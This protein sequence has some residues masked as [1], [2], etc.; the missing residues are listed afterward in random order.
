MVERIPEEVLKTAHLRWCRRVAAAV[1]MAMAETGATYQQLEAR[2]GTKPGT[3]KRWLNK[4]I[5]GTTTEGRE[6]TDICCALNAE[7]TLTIRHWADVVHEYEPEI[8]SKEEMDEIE[9]AAL[10]GAVS[11]Q[12]EP[13]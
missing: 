8:I 11:S 3:T 13:S 12:K 6:L 10:A 4:Y 5:D 1:I 9:R 7:P 2:M